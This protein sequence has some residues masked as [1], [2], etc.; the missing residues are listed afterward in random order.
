LSSVSKRETQ[1]LLVVDDE[2][3]IKLVLRTALERQ[4]YVVLTN[5]SPTNALAEFVPNKF[6]LVIC[7]I[8]MPEM[9]GFTLAEKMLAID[10]KQKV[11]FLT[12]YD[13]GYLE[14]FSRR[15]PNLPRHC[16]AKKPVSIV[17]LLEMVRAELD[18]T[19][20]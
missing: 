14:E 3:D 5:C 10:S 20:S 12:A 7:D 2:E 19:N 8:R 16:F 15:F 4:G 17:D 13:E 18:R 1:T 11:C 9:D 6:D